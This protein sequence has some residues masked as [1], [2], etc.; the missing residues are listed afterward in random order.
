MYSFLKKT[1]AYDI[2]IKWKVIK[3]KYRYKLTNLIY[4][5][6]AVASIVAGIVLKIITKKNMFIGIGSWLFAI[7]T[8]A[9]II[10]QRVEVKKLMSIL[11]PLDEIERVKYAEENK[12]KSSTYSA[13][14]TLCLILF[15]YYVIN[16]DYEKAKENMFFRINKS[17]FSCYSLYIYYLHNKEY[18]KL[19]ELFEK[20]VNA[21]DLRLK[22]QQDSIK[23]IKNL[24]YN[25]IYS[26]KLETSR[27]EYVKKMCEDYKSGKFITIETST[28]K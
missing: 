24:A 12:K 21:K 17:P 28:S 26:E 11:G 3:M 23:L 20:L 5:L 6:C 13:F 27:Y 1:M 25:G 22:P 2:I 9:I 8:I 14:A 18:D 19:E 7:F 10:L 15:N 16:G 4:R